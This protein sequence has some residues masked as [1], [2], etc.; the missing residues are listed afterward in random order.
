[1]I[2]ETGFYGSND[3]TNSE[4]KAVLFQC[5]VFL[6]VAVEQHLVITDQSV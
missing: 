6:K 5:I 1:M 3:S 2:S 4:G